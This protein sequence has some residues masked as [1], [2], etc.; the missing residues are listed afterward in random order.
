V[1]NPVDPMKYLRWV[2]LFLVFFDLFIAVP[3]LLFPQWVIGMAKMNTDAVTGAMYRSGPIEPIF[4]RGIGVLWLL[5]AY[6]QYIAWKDPAA[7]MQ[8]VNIAIV[9][10]LAG[11]TFEL[12]EAAYLLP[13]VSFG[14]PLV[15]WVLGI[16]VVGDYLLVAVMAYL[17][18]RLGLAWWR[19]GDQS[20]AK[21]VS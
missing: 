16:F 20:P 19:L 14:Q 11:G 2:L 7:R 8:A 5:A 13:R 21:G 3:A 10:R 1:K 17:L 4:L 9:F 18:R 12:I 6:I 15:Y